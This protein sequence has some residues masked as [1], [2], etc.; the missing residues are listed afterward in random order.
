LV[1]KFFRQKPAAEVV[2]QEHE[3]DPETY[4]T[5]LTKLLG[6]R[7]FRFGLP[8]TARPARWPLGNL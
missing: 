6:I 3:S 4:E 2:L 8:S 7:R 1:Q 5:P